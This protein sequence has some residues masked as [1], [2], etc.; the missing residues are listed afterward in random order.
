MFEFT[1]MCN[2]F[3][4]LSAVERGVILTEKSVKVLAMLRLYDEPDIDPVETLATFILGSIVSDGKVDEKEYLLMY[5]ALV[6]VFG[7]NFD[8]EAVKAAVAKDNKARKTIKNYS[9][10]LL[11]VLAEIDESF[12]E[13]IITLCLCVVTID[14]KISLKE[15]KYIKKLIKA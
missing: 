10:E 14:G 3:E 9:R 12:I 8:F 1:K 13:D 6:K 5:P 11:K 4:K 7:E 2:E 15:R